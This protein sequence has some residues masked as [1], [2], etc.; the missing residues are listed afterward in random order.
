MEKDDLD[1][2]SWS[3]K[4]IVD[5]LYK[6]YQEF[7]T[8][9]QVWLIIKF[10]QE[11]MQAQLLKGNDVNIPKLGTF[12]PRTMTTYVTFRMIFFKPDFHFFNLLKQRQVK[13]F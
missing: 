11:Q 10:A 13:N 4:F 5:I 6:K 3:Q 9:Y 8:R 1:F 7:A 12:S 2:V